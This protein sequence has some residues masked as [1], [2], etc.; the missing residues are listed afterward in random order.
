ME[1]QSLAS[2]YKGKNVLVT[3]HT[4]FKGT[5]LCK[6]LS[7][8]GANVYGYALPP[9]ADPSIYRILRGDDWIRSVY[10]DVRD[11][12]RFSACIK[13]AAPEF[14]FHLAAQPIVRESYRR[15][16]ETYETNVMGTVNL[17]ESVR[18]VS[19]VRG[20]LNVTTDKV[21]ENESAR[22]HAFTEDEK[23][24]GH[25]PYSNSKSCSELVTHAY[26]KS[27]FCGAHA[28]AVSTARAGNVIGGGD[29]AVDRLIPDCV[30]ATV[31]GK[32]ISIRNPFSTRPYQHVLDAVGAYLLIMMKQTEDIRL[33]GWYNVGPD[34]GCTATGDLADLFANAW[35]NGAGWDRQEEPDAPCEAASLSLD[36][37][38]I[39]ATL[40]W[41]PVWPLRDAAERTVEWYKVWQQ[42]GDC[43]EA[44]EKQIRAYLQ[45]YCN[46]V[47]LQ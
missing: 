31:Q 24:D 21:Y 27:F 26:Q 23:L 6:V 28:V 15:P 14:V 44:T 4:G 32:R 5:W 43:A 20:I 41:R 29:F 17:L 38:K 30:R 1:L 3:G 19:C 18:H 13:N 12:E 45:K 37:T 9:Q 7:M 25:D 39:K 8:M 35:G 40:G 22:A 46:I 2:F 33:A 16:R 42:N 36:C 34:E 11:Y 10:G 47:A